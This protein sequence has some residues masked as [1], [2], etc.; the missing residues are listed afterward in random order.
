[1]PQLRGNEPTLG[2]NNDTE[3]SKDQEN[4]QWE[5]QMPVAENPQMEKIVDQR[6]GKKTK[7]KTYFEY[8]VKWKGHPIED[9]S[10]DAGASS[11]SLRG[12]TTQRLSAPLNHFRILTAGVSCK[13]F[14]LK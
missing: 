4:I 11:A 10:C 7:R 3:R 12:E 6:I 14:F 9:A 1:M 8:L 13:Y 2:L 5:M